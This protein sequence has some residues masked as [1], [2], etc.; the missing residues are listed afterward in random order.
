MGIPRNDFTPAPRYA[1]DLCED[2][3]R[4]NMAHFDAM[5]PGPPLAVI[6]QDEE[7][8]YNAWYIQRRDYGT[9]GHVAYAAKY[10]TVAAPSDTYVPAGA[11]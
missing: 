7:F 10:G 9:M 5:L 2:T 8:R 3:R 6:A 11:A 1:S 4:E